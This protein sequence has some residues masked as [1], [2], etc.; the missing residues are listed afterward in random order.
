MLTDPIQIEFEDRKCVIRIRKSKK[1]I[2][3]NG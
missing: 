2:Q 1:N 3:H